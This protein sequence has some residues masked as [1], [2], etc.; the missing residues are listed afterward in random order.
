LRRNDEELICDVI[1]KEIN[2]VSLLAST[3]MS[4]GNTFLKRMLGR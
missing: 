2:F 3:R 4:A 1:K